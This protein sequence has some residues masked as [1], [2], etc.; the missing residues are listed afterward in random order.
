MQLSVSQLSHSSRSYAVHQSVVTGCPCN[1]GTVCTSDCMLCCLCD[2]ISPTAVALHFV[3]GTICNNAHVYDPQ[4]CVGTDWIM[5]VVGDDR[6]ARCKACDVVLPAH[7]A[8][9][10]KHSQN[11]QHL[12]HLSDLNSPTKKTS[13]QNVSFSNRKSQVSVY[14]HVCQHCC[15]VSSPWSHFFIVNY[16]Y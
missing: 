13:E 3:I 2:V 9:L 10:T 16:G 1:R 5:A 6:S 14:L 7:H 12:Q 4:V 8:G 11:S 15:T